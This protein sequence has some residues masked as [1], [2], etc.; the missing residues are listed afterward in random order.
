MIIRKL[1]LKSKWSL[2]DGLNNF[3]FP[4][5]FKPDI[6][7]VRVLCFHGICDDDTAFINGR[8]MRISQFRVLIEALKKRC[9]IISLDDYLAHRFDSTKLNILLTFDDGYQNNKDLL[10]PIIEPLN[11]PVTLFVT[12]RENRSLWADLLDILQSKNV[13]L[14]ELEH[15]FTGIATRT[16]GELKQWIPTLSI[17]QLEQL[18]D[19]LDRL[20]QSY[21]AET[22]VFWKLLSRTEVESLAKHPLVSIANHSA[23]HT[24]FT[25]LT[26]TEMKEELDDCRDY[27]N[28]I[29]SK[30]STVFAYPY[31]RYSDTTVKQLTKWGYP[32]QFITEKHALSQDNAIE[33]LI[34]NPFISLRNQLIAIA[35]GRY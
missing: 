18:T 12:R 16:N 27:L 32:I 20:A 23:N 21:L 3:G 30:H 22:T 11:V 26:P 7:S 6:G 1:Y 29:G 17:D 10:L 5:R 19:Q 4:M 25:V 15:L 31:A 33:R 24:D 34:V 28:A 13:K 2:Q 35:H 9:T 14:T 8:F